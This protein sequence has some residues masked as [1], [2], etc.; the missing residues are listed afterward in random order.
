MSS[1]QLFVVVVWNF[2]VYML[3]MALLML[4]VWNYVSSSIRGTTETVSRPGRQNSAAVPLTHFNLFLSPYCS[5]WTPCLSGRTKK[6]TE[7]TR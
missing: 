2:E 5:P 6:R 7:R 4:L 3:P 1:S